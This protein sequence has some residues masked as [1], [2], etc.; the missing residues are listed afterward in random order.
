MRGH[1]RKR[2]EGS[3]T[4]VVE[5]PRDPE[6]GRRRQKWVT[7]KGP[8][9]EAERVLAELITQV[10][11]GLAAQAPAKM[12][13]GQYLEQWL[14]SIKGT[15][16]E[17]TWQTRYYLTRE[18]IRLL[19][20]VPLSKLTSLQVQKAIANLPQH[21]KN[22]SKNA[23]WHV[24]NS[25][26]NRAVKW[27]LIAKNP[28]S[29]TVRPKEEKRAVR[30]W[31]EEEAA[32]FLAATKGHR[33]YALFYLALATGMRLGE[34][35]GLRWKD[36]DLEAGII[37]ISQI[38]G[39]GGEPTTPKTA[40]SRRKIP[41]DPETIAV[42]RL[43]RKRQLEERM[44][45]GLV[46]LSDDDYVFSAKKGTPLAEGT[47]EEAFKE[48]QRKSGVPPI[49][50]HDLRHT[51]ATF[52]LRQGVHPKIVAERLGH[53]KV[54]ITLDTY[55]HVLPDSQQEAVRAIQRILGRGRSG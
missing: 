6:T 30:V 27:G 16:K 10:E 15:V 53:S 12:K 19:G 35:R 26:F 18:W 3:W 46:W 55:S 23:A 38:I 21:W 42:I 39:P 41:I 31:T 45:N 33:W 22:S 20:D 44:A 4:V 2:S 28:V 9:K 50:F 48:V 29:G 11:S 34:L 49:R 40:G 37:A 14:E 52:L 13:V 51:H 36:I 32:K 1:I 25:A 7:V 47:V 24:L 5:L 17:S 43:H 54:S 8:K